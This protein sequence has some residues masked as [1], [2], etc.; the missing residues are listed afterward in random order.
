MKD[1]IKN[2]TVAAVP[3]VA[4]FVLNL[5]LYV[6]GMYVSFPY[7]RICLGVVLGLLGGCMLISFVGEKLYARR[8]NSMAGDECLQYILSNTKKL[9]EAFDHAEKTLLRLK[10]AVIVYIVFIVILT[11]AF[12]FSF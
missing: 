3:Y 9:R 5:A 11:L 7:G 8:F 2:A 4:A 10:N 12:L 1:K 6:A